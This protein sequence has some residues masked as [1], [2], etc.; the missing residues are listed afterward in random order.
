MS[1]E[2]FRAEEAGARQAASRLILQEGG[3][4]V[5]IQVLLKVIATTA[6]GAFICDTHTET[7]STDAPTPSCVCLSTMC[8]DIPQGVGITSS[9]LIPLLDR[10]EGKKVF[11]DALKH[12]PDALLPPQQKQHFYDAALDDRLRHTR[13][14]NDLLLRTAQHCHAQA[15]KTQFSAA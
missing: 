10:P 13:D 5:V 4:A 6:I 2:T 11:L 12:L 1:A 8:A 3:L 15:K 9:A 14:F 7:E